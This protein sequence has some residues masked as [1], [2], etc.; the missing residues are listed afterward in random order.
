MIC[1]DCIHKPVC[2]N[3]DKMQDTSES[4]VIFC[5]RKQTEAK[6]KISELELW[7]D[8]MSDEKYVYDDYKT[9]DVSRGYREC[10]E[11]YIKAI[12]KQITKLKGEKPC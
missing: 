1:D 6:I 2:M 3:V 4:T 5:G 7:R 8:A 12:D 10:L 11:N 9:N